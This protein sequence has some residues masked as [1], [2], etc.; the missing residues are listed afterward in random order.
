MNWNEL[1]LEQYQQ[2][3]R[4]I[5]KPDQTN[6]DV[7]VEV[8]STCEGI[9]IDVIDSW[10]YD[11][12]LSK[13]NDYKFLEEMDFDKT[14]KSFINVNGKRYKFIHEVGKMPAARYIESKVYSATDLINNLHS[15]MASCVMP[16]KKNWR[17]KWVVDK[18]DAARHSEYA[19][20]MQAAKFTEVYNCVVF[21]YHLLNG[22]IV[23][24]EDYLE[25]HMKEIVKNP[26]VFL[27]ALTSTMAGFT[28]PSKSQPISE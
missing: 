4:I 18:Y 7:M 27:N 24:L 8:I 20:D 5:A 15:V 26:K 10:P 6:L 12:L 17:G 13:Q 21:F 22:L 28:Q 2:L 23:N 16:M 1:T 11:K 9:P 19:K 25:A 14:A 3:H